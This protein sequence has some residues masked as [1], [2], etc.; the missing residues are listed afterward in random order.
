[1]AKTSG[2]A[3]LAALQNKIVTTEPVEEV[4]VPTSVTKVGNQIIVDSTPALFESVEDEQAGVEESFDKSSMEGIDDAV[5]EPEHESTAD[6][7]PEFGAEESFESSTAESDIASKLTTVA[8]GMDSKLV[9]VDEMPYLAVEP[10]EPV[11]DAPVE[12]PAVKES[13]YVLHTVDQ[14]STSELEAYI[15]GTCEEE[16]YVAQLKQAVYEH[17]KREVTLA[18]A[19]TVEECREYFLTGKVPAKTSKGAWVKDA[20]RQYRREHE[21]ETNELES[22][23]LGE[24]KAEGA[25]TDGGLAVELKQRLNLALKSFD[26]NA[27]ITNYRYTTNQVNETRTE[28]RPEPQTQEVSEARVAEVTKAIQL[29]GVTAVNQSYIDS[30]LAQYEAVM[31][32]GRAITERAAGEAQVLLRDVI[33]YAVQLPDP[34]GARSAMQY[35]LDHFRARRAI[36]ELFE[37]TYAYRGIP[38]MRTTKKEQI[39]HHD[40]LTL[41]LVYADLMVELRGQTDIPSLIGAVNPQF[42]SR[43]LEFF[44]RQ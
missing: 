30:S 34:V 21:W 9:Q 17:R 35:L 32:P 38:D 31:K 10:A 14:W 42:Q 37:D 23:A 11:F 19:W 16:T 26:V 36:G 27:I 25:T 33:R 22:W 6:D 20:T 5:L 7:V 8:R 4:V 43:V 18:K 39:A 2:F 29:E 24:I 41:F 15:S 13:V 1:M 44:A 12:E 40:L 3:A 28:I